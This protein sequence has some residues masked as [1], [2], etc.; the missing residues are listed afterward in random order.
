MKLTAP[1]FTQ[2]RS[3][4]QVLGQAARNALENKYAQAAREIMA[5]DMSIPPLTGPPL[6]GVQ[7]G[8]GGSV[9]FLA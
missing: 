6:E 8:K 9:D 1:D 3:V 4:T 2:L 7:L 5:L